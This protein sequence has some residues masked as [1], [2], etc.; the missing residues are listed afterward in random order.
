MWTA[1]Q[2]PYTFRWICFECSLFF[3][4]GYLKEFRCPY[5]PD[6]SFASRSRLERHSQG[7]GHSLLVLEMEKLRREERGSAGAVLKDEKKRGGSKDE[8][9]RGDSKDEK[10]KDGSKDE[11]KKDGSKDEKKKDDSMDE[12]KRGGSKDE[13]K[14]DGSKDVKKPG[15]RR[16]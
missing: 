13:N 4:Y 2:T 3:R 16:D 5:C 7:A 15:D 10:K 6:V 14:R 11:K 12:K 1:D 8:E 9:K